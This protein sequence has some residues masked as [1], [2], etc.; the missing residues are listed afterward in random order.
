MTTNYNTPSYYGLPDDILIAT[1]GSNIT[2][3]DKFGF[4]GDIGATERTVWDGAGNTNCNYLSA[5]IQL[6]ISSDDANDTAAGTGARV[7]E[8]SGL[9]ANY[10]EISEEVTLDGI[11]PVTTVNSYIR[12]FRQRVRAHTNPDAVN[13]GS[14]YAFIGTE[15]AGVPIDPDQIFSII[16]PGMNRTLQANYT[17]P[18]NRI[19]LL[20]FAEI[21]S[22]GGNNAEVTARLLMRPLGGV[23]E[24]MRKF[25]VE[26]GQIDREW[27][28]PI[29]M[30]A[31]A[32][33]EIRAER[34]SGAGTLN[35][36]AEFDMRLV[37]KG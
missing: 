25:V 2:Q 6:Q 10:A 31:K 23:W 22:L 11:T 9:D 35:V 34:T 27:K 19:G 7:I 24:T 36:S 12:C 15:T 14:I 26:K 4:A 28:P 8:V 20:D 16:S 3:I 33:I 29:P 18:A 13:A 21:I 37:P 1:G 32:D 17:V 30:P 5:A